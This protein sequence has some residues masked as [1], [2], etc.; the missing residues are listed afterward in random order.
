M[1]I[2]SLAKLAR[3]KM[4]LLLNALQSGRHSLA[5]E[6]LEHFPEV[7]TPMERCVMRTMQCAKVLHG[8]RMLCN[9]CMHAAPWSTASPAVFPAASRCK[10]ACIQGLARLPAAA[11]SAPAMRT[12]PACAP[13]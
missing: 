5:L 9:A 8:R 6:L 10:G 7:V 1:T 3:S 4:P 11:S 12:L 2:T 13:T